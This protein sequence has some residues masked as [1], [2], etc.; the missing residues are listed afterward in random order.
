MKGI[1]YATGKRRIC[2]H[3]KTK[4]EGNF[5]LPLKKPRKVPTIQQKL[6]VVR[7]C[8][9][10]KEKKE[11]AKK[12]LRAPKTRGGT[13][14]QKKKAQEERKEARKVCKVN[15]QKACEEKF[16]STVGGAQVCK[17][18]R[19]CT[20]ESWEEIP[21]M[22]RTRI[23]ATNNAW[24]SKLGLAKKGTKQGGRIPHCLQVEVDRL[25][26]EMVAGESAVS[27]RKEVVTFECLVSWLKHCSALSKHGSGIAVCS[28]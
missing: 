10:L 3:R 6:E 1:E 17:W 9:Q 4:D 24:R 11:E 14:A 5:P 27:C 2:K 25:I 16:G 26:S 28:Y 15:Y 22:V 12:V 18:D 8:R 20:I 13:R 21:E 19:M 23:S 7:Y